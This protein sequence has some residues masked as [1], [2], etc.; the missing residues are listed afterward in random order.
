MKPL[1]LLRILTVAAAALTAHAEASVVIAGTRVVFPSSER[2]VTVQLTND[3]KRPAL[4]Q[5]WIDDGDRNALPEQID[6]PFTLTPAMFRMEPGTGQTL[7]VMHTGQPLPADK[8]SLFWLNVLEV[9]PKA[10]GDDNP[11]RMQLAF[12][13]R[14]KIM[15]R[16]ASL[17]GDANAAPAQLD[18]RVIRA[19]GGRYALQ[20]TNPTSYVVNLGSVMLK[21]AGHKYD[22]G[23]GY[24]LPGATQ[25]FPIK[26]LVTR[27][28]AGA[29][30]EF[31][32]I[33]D[34]GAS[35]DI[36]HPV[37]VAP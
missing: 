1:K 16:P 12:R 30:V 32:A 24:V 19:D 26:D 21:S 2:E 18:W 28:V 33:N 8:E 25:R 6:V 27:P 34:W 13:S 7:R 37:S 11:N 17:K 15:Y 31:A 23:S 10:T 20:A 35:A 22:A 4:V 5:A 9:P 36:E 29:A 14:I 3:G